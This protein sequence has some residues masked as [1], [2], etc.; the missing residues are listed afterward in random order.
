MVN[1]AVRINIVRIGDKP[2][3]FELN[4]DENL[5]RVLL[6]DELRIKQILNNLLSNAIKYTKAGTV[7]L[8]VYRE[9]ENILVCKVS[10]TGIGIRKED[11]GRLFTEYSQ[12]DA[13][14][15]RKIEGTGLGLAI[16]KML[17]DLMGGTVAVESEYGRGS[18]FI[19]RI[20]Q[21]TVDPSPLGRERA[22]KLEAL[23]YFDGGE[24]ERIVPAAISGD[25]RVLVVDDV[26]INLDVAR[27]L[28]EPYGLTV[29]TVLSGKEAV[30]KIRS[31]E[32][33]YDMVLM[34]HMMPGMD[35]V[36]AVRIIRNEIGTDYARNVPIIALT[37]NALEGN[38]EMF[39]GNGFNGYISKPID[40]R[41]LDEMLKK[42]AGKEGISA[43]PGDGQKY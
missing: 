25:I 5:P 35:G 16:T 34:D 26:D 2:I 23:E 27:G 3:T 38:E 42:W 20:P 8:D 39:L 10:D 7:R 40:I 19:I 28:L 43:P 24:E 17:L 15:N 6:G 14:A 1:D 4:V 9:G 11:A 31:G 37:A 41:L 13:R 21:Q 36:E 12:L 18:V 32:G 30:E 22:E 29:D 33:R